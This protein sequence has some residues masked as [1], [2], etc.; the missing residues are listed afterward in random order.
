MRALRCNEDHPLREHLAGESTQVEE[1][2]FNRSLMQYATLDHL[3][4]VLHAPSSIDLFAGE[5]KR[6]CTERARKARG[7]STNKRVRNEIVRQF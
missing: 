1:N 3:P 6:S 7:E 4:R 5:R 2:R